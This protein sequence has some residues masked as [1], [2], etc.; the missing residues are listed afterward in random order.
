MIKI[1]EIVKN[2]EHQK[3]FEFAKEIGKKM[4]IPVYL[5]GGYI[6]DAFL[7]KDRADIDIMVGN[8]VFKFSEALSKDLKVNTTVNFEK[9]Q[10]SRIPYEGCEIEIAN[11]RKEIYD[12][13]S[14]KPS[15][16]EKTS[17]FLD[18]L[19]AVA[20]PVFVVGKNWVSRYM[21]CARSVHFREFL[22]K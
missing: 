21:Y 3:I 16:V 13:N 12:S 17:L 18:I 9:F 7:Q 5:V 11:A 8:N 19:I 22:K 1:S 20:F 15:K 4:N 6:R 2:K 14:R 10:T